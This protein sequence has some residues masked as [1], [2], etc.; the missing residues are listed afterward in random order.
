M[1]IEY[2]K[3]LSYEDMRKLYKAHLQ[4]QE[5][6]RNTI[7]TVAGDTFY[8]WNNG[9]KELFWDTV[10][11]VDFETAARSAL[12]DAL[13]KNSTGN[14]DKLHYISDRLPPRFLRRAFSQRSKRPVRYLSSSFRYLPY[15]SP[16]PEDL[17][18]RR[19]V[20]LLFLSVRR[21]QFGLLSTAAQTHHRSDS[22]YR[23]LTNLRFL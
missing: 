1:D 15:L 22:Y 4:S 5:L 18:F 3:S 17:L 14:V 21:N 19:L 2:A 13:T 10:M 11:A 23:N 12:T 20:P 7:G 8:L 16:F 6:G 9:G